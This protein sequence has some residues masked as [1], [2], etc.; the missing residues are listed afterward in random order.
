MQSQASAEDMRPNINSKLHNGV[1]ANV[2]RQKFPGLSICTQWPSSSNEKP[3]S[4]FEGGFSPAHDAY[5]YITEWK[6]VNVEFPSNDSVKISLAPIHGS[7]YPFVHP[8]RGDEWRFVPNEGFVGTERI[9][10]LVSFGEIKIRIKYLF[11]VTTLPMDSDEAESLCGRGPKRKEFSFDYL[12][13]PPNAAYLAPA[14]SRGP[15]PSFKRSTNGVPP[16]PGHRYGVQ[17][18]WPGPGVTPLAPA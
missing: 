5:S 4:I 17:C 11:M 18:L 16:G 6:K 14:G 7:V 15:N 12:S 3:Y 1:S 13:S 10:A 9:E 2:V 8:N